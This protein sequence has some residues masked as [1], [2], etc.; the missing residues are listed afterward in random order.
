MQHDD[1]PPRRGTG[2]V[3]FRKCQDS[4][5]ILLVRAANVQEDWRFPIELVA[6]GDLEWQSALRTLREEAGV[7]GQLIGS[8]DD[9]VTSR[10]HHERLAV[11]FH[12]IKATAEEPSRARTEHV[13]LPIA[14]AAEALPHCH[15]RFVLGE[16]VPI[17]EGHLSQSGAHDAAFQKFLLN[18][19]D[20]ATDSF[21]KSEE[22]GERRAMFFLTVAAGAGAVAAFNLGDQG[23]TPDQRPWPLIIV[24]VGL[25]GFGCLLMLRL[26]TR[27][28]RTD[29]YKAGLRR[30]RRWFIPNALDPRRAC[31]PF[32]PYG[33]DDQ[34]DPPTWWPKKGGWLEALTLANAILVGVWAGAV[35][36]TSSWPLEGLVMLVGTAAAWCLFVLWARAAK[37]TNDQ[38]LRDECPFR[39][40]CPAKDAEH[41]THDCAKPCR[42]PPTERPLR[43]PWRRRSEPNSNA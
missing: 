12:V 42:P 34:R 24:L 14:L 32:D 27:N 17:M 10:W 9:R 38:R 5:E 25:I 16:T 40:K 2:A 28:Q 39:R 23:Y 19:L 4:L 43:I 21:F 20:H 35:F 13:W 31:L 11:R 6:P 29:D 22:D 8:V 26:I 36:N 33:K 7:I 18:E 37:K 3:A 41:E 15:D 1:P 30:G